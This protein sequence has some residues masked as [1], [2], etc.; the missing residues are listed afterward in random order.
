MN[1]MPLINIRLPISNHTIVT[2]YKNVSAIYTTSN[3]LAP[4]RNILALVT[5]SVIKHLPTH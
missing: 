2:S 5:Y 3:M 1:K 4:D